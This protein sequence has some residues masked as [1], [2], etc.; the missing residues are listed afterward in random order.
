MVAEDILI[1][2]GVKGFASVLLTR[3]GVRLRVAAVVVLAS[4]CSLVPAPPRKGRPH[5]VEKGRFQALYD[6]EGR[7]E[8]VAYDSDGDGRAE[9]V[10]FFGP[11]GAPTRAQID[12][13]KDGIVDRWESYGPDGRLAKVGTSRRTRGIPDTWSYPDGFGGVS[14]REYDEDG[15]GKAE[16]AEDLLDGTVVAEEFDT[17]RSGSW[18]RRVVRGPDGSV[19]R[20]DRDPDGQGH[21]EHSVD[22]S[23]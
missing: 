19:V 18:D 1:A 23:K 8:R 20:V 17:T 6:G 10:T 12:S 5:L 13:D 9:V 22:V 7:L 4:G 3:R 15:D 11:D 16:R 21:W 2:N 14:R